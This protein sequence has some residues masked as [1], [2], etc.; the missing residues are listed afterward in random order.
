MIAIE[1]VVAWLH[2]VT[3]ARSWQRKSERI[4]SRCPPTPP[5]TIG[6]VDRPVIA[7]RASYGAHS[8]VVG[9]RGEQT[10]EEIVQSALRAFATQGFH[11]TSVDDIAT[12][13]D[14]SRA[15][16]Y[17]YFESKES[18]FVELIDEGGA[19]LLGLLDR[20]A[21]FGASE[22]GFAN[23]SAWVTEWVDIFEGLSTVFI[24]WAKVDSPETVLREPLDTFT[25]RHTRRL[26]RHLVVAGV[27]EERSVPC[28]VLL[29]AV[30]SRAN[31]LRD[32]Y[33]PDPSRRSVFAADLA[34][35]FQRF[36]FPREDKHRSF[37][38]AASE[39]IGESALAEVRPEFPEADDRLVGLR[40][41]GR[42]T[43]RRL[44]DAAATVFASSGYQA[45]TVEQIASEAGVA[46]GTFYKYFTDKLDVLLALAEEACH[47]HMTLH[48]LGDLTGREAL[49][50]W[51]ERLLAFGRENTAVLRAWTERV[52]DNKELYTLAEAIG[53]ASRR[54]FTR[55]VR[56][57]VAPVGNISGVMMLMAVIE[58]FPQMA[59]SKSV[60][61]S[62][63]AV[64]DATFAFVIDGILGGI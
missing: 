6:N 18:L 11:V 51:L 40:T 53:M 8:P 49:I 61:I 41:Q 37:D 13:A 21:P 48:D 15:T 63:E 35:A 7:R 9:E 30:L 16:L 31:Y 14:V 28:A 64:H 2:V 36:L 57:S 58:Y 25:R 54:R 47:V 44:L 26:A 27:S 56:Q 20:I 34:K 29:A 1:N 23:L 42:K 62:P 3:L 59:Y 46:R 38:D 32:L 22:E 45:A 4:R 52:P 19:A 5:P 10:R 12:G 39:L 17:Q 24:E 60:K 43:V 55:F 50:E 33:W